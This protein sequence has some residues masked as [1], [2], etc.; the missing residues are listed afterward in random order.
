MTNNKSQIANHKS[1]ISNLQSLIS[2]YLIFVI[3]HL[4]FVISCGATVTPPAPVYL[5]ATGSTA[6]TPLLHDLAAAYHE[7]QPDVT[8]DINTGGSALGRELASAG[9]VDLGLTSWLPDGPPQGVQATV[10]AR[11]GIALIVHPSNAVRGLT[12][13]QVHDLF[14]GSLGDWQAV[15]GAPAAVQTVSREDGS[16][17]RAAFEALVMQGSRVTPMALVMPNSQA[18]VDYVARDPRAIGYVSMGYV[19]DKVRVVAVEGLVPNPQNVS[20]AEYNLTRDLV[21]LTRPDAPGAVRAFLD[22]VLSPAGQ[23]IVGQRYGR[24]R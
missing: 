10:V 9:Q 11:D 23:A 19:G 5:K 17:T 2:R 12:L 3:C 4:I 21:I 15:G 18:V 24:V 13:A 8:I 14:Q 20:R 1:P 16:G 6:M 22:F 7:R